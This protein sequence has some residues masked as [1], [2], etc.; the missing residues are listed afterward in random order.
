M[1]RI[2]AVLEGFLGDSGDSP[3]AAEPHRARWYGGG[4][5]EDRRIRT[6]FADDLE[7]A[8]SGALDAWCQRASGSLALVLLL[9]QCTRT[10]YRR[11]PRAYAGD[12]KAYAVASVAVALGQDRGLDVPARIL[13]YHP[14]HHSERL[15][16]QERVLSLLAGMREE[17][18]PRWRPY[19]ERSIDGFG[20]HRNIVAR[21]GRFPHRNETLGR[22]SSE[23]ELE[24]LA[25]GAERFGQ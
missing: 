2:D 6:L 24:H 10:L 8:L 12:P 18:T 7:Q 17:V 3:E 23:A 5:E 1:S 15:E 20:R 25:G 19:V 9:D 14:F 21:F 16:D 11:T 4:E 13:L 22:T